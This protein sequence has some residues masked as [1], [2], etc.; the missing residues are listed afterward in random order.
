[1][2]FKPE[3]RSLPMYIYED[4]SFLKMNAIAIYHIKS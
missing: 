3:M 2:S 4:Y 1:M